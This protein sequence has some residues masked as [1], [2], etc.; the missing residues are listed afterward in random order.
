MDAD[1]VASRKRPIQEVGS[2]PA[3]STAGT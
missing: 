2:K 3:A 1:A